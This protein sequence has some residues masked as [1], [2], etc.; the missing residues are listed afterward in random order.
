MAKHVYGPVPSRRLGYSLGVDLVP[1]KVCSFDCIYCQ[2]GR[3][4]EKTVERRE[5]ARVDEILAEI[6]SA[7]PADKP[8]D[9][10]TL[11]GSGEPT[12]SS[13]T[14][15]LVHEIKRLTR[16]PVAI[17]TNSSLLHNEE[18]RREVTS[19]DLLLP[20]L[21]AAQECT[22]QKI[23]RPHPSLKLSEIVAGLTHLREE[24]AGVIWLEVMLV[25][26]IN[27]TPQE[28]EALRDTIARIRPDKVQLNT[29]MR[30]PSE[31]SA[32]PLNARELNDIRTRLGS[33]CEIIPHFP[34]RRRS[35]TAKNTAEEILALVKR[36]PVT[37]S[38]LVR[39]LG[40]H[41]NE[42]IKHL[43]LLE[44]K[45]KIRTHTHRGLQY[46]EQS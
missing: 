8:I 36:R 44:R 23:N 4:T 17:L 12:L 2:I 7:V 26:G 35:A 31:K 27:D 24:Y 10:I 29:V 19:A 25:K 34:Q 20:S 9:Y 5:Y 32:H 21:D 15:T 18:A 28:I 45:R 42:A 43:N 14:G 41:R 33:R 46:Y 3:T 1:Y 22:F 38:D 16:V 30:P 37:L 40:I 11:S 6:S 39:S 13:I